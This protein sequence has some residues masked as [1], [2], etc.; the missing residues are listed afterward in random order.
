MSQTAS[1]LPEW[2]LFHVPHDSVSI[3]DYCRG[4]FVLTDEELERELIR[5]T[6]LHTLDL[7]TGGI[8]HEQV[9]RFPVS[10]LLV[11]PER[12][13][14]DRDE[15]MAAKGQGAIYSAASDGRRLK[16]SLSAIER[17]YL[18]ERYYFPHHRILTCGVHA[19]LTRY[20]KALIV[21]CHS[22]SSVPLPLEPV[23][24][25][26]RPQICIGTDPFHTPPELVSSLQGVFSA[27]GLSV[28]VDD[29][30]SGS[31]APMFHYGTDKRVATFMLEVR[32]NMYEEESTGIKNAGFRS[33]ADI[34]RRAVACAA[35][36]FSRL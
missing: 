17:R 6:D 7:F 16:R 4:L 13:P 33:T 36:V 15:P 1:V 18:M 3:P 32:R 25:P 12:F 31:L 20:G 10:R 35:D 28:S 5:M 27:A 24:H 34:L 2:V 22:F 8:P 14:E 21:D 19:A 30:F 26:C 11:D 9:F 23:R 29:P